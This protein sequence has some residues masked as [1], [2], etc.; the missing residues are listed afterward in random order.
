MTLKTCHA[1][2]THVGRARENNQDRW[3]ADRRAG[4]YLVADGMGG[5]PAGELAAQVVADTLPALVERRLPAGADLAA[6]ETQ[7]A[8]LAAIGELSDRLYQESRQQPGLSGMGSTVVLGLL[9]GA[10]ALVAHLGD[11]RAYLLR[12]GRLERLTQ[13]HSIVE[14]LLETGDIQ[15][16]EVA[17]HP[18][19]GQLTR[20]VGMPGEPLPEARLLELRAGDRLLLCSDGLSGMV[21]DE[22]LREILGQGKWPR[23]ACRKLINAANRAGGRDNVTAVVVDLLLAQSDSSSAQ[24]RRLD[25]VSKA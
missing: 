18:A 19:R 7:E 15:P 20:F 24:T 10:Q 1:G 4:L 8:L 16:E 12:D 14:L 21:S 3:F 22:Q 5:G 13:D 17:G 25:N 6:P 11:S 2:L 9:R 23:G